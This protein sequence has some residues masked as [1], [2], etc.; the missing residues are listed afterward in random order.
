M[1]SEKDNLPSNGPNIL[2][3]S[4]IFLVVTAFIIGAYL[5]SR[6]D[7]DSKVPVDEVFVCGESE[8]SDNDGNRYGTVLIGEQCWTSENLRSETGN[9]GLP[10]ARK[11]YD[12]DPENCELYGALYDWRNASFACPTGWELPSDDDF[13]EL[14]GYLGMDEE[15][16][17]EWGWRHSGSLARKLMA[18]GDS[19]FNALMAGLVDESD[20]FEAFGVYTSFWTSTLLGNDPYRRYMSTL[21]EGVLRGTKEQI[22]GYS[23]R[24]IQR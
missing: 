9:D 16:L 20:E 6:R 1:A 3:I 19:G 8:M 4:A 2:K 14:E 21:D 10:V 5:I 17:D 12:D 13:K 18:G 15:E 11:C 7:D 23:V 22:Y 24:C